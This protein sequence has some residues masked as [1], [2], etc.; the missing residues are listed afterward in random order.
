MTD[1]IQ[2]YANEASDA[3]V[4]DVVVRAGR[5][6]ARHGV[7]GDYRLHYEEGDGAVAVCVQWHNPD[8]GEWVTA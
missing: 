2:N 8:S 4:A 1:P 7:H 5:A 3:M 6:V